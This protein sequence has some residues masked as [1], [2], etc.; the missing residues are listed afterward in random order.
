MSKAPV[1]VVGQ[2]VEATGSYMH[3]ITKGKLYTVTGYT[4]EDYTPTFTWPA[5]VEVVGD[6][7]KKVSGHTHRFKALP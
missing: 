2:V 5:Y 6:F 7:G 1:F 4:P 3:Q